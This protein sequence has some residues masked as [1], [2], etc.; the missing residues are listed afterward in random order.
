MAAGGRKSGSV[1]IFVALILIIALAVAAYLFRDTLFSLAAP[2]APQATVAPPPQE[3]VEVV[4]L[5]QQLPLGATITEAAVTTIKFPKENF[6]EGLYFKAVKDVVG[7]R[8]KYPLSSGIIL[9]TGVLSAAPVGSF[10]SSQIPPGYVAISIPITRLTSVS[11]ALQPGDH[12][13]VILALM[14]DELDPNF[15]T[16]LPNLTGS[17]IAPGPIGEKGAGGTAAT[18]T[19]TGGGALQGRVELDPTLNQPIY[20]LPSEA[21]RPRIVSQ[22][23]ISD[24]TVLGI[25]RFAQA[26][27]AETSKTPVPASGPT[28]TPAPAVLQD[29]DMITL[30]VTPQDSVA[31]NYILLTKG[32]KM[33]LVLRSASDTKQVKT[34]AV[35]LQFLMDQYAIPFPS[36][37]PY[38]L[39]P[40]ADSLEYQGQSV[41][42]PATTTK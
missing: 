20:V 9:T 34:E 30:I 40:R 32:A 37:L 19:I 23:L 39:E 1:F 6:V 29:P 18:T 42:P 3:Q 36:K 11:Y 26:S 21:Q 41:Q 7:K 35:T 33:N 5:T 28:P 31:I 38:G 14:L 15:Q 12:V 27:L 2:A 13:S 24:A 4:V 8:V 10:A 17:V 22:I 25:G 16:K